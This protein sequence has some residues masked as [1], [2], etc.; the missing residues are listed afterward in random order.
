MV[1]FSRT[2]FVLSNNVYNAV[3]QVIEKLGKGAQGVVY[4]AEHKNGKK[5]ALKKV[6]RVTFLS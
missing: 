1:T 5:F 6:S 3:F 2:K 4:L